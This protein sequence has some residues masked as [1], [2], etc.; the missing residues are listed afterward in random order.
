MR[1]YIGRHYNIDNYHCANLV[2]DY[3]RDKFN[4]E[5]PVDEAF[6]VSFTRWMRKHCEPIALPVN[7]CIVRMRKDGRTHVGIYTEY[8]VLHNFKPFYGL[9]S[10]VHWPLGVVTRNYDKVEYFKW[11]E[12]DTTK[13]QPRT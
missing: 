6:N 2:A 10:V 9:G 1:E 11:S 7:D 13:T 4:V 3:Y 8:G 12:L 5:L